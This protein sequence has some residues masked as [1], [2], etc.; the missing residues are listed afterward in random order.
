MNW[1]VAEALFQS[2][3]APQIASYSPLIERTYFLVSADAETAANEKA[4]TLARSKEHSYANAE[5]DTVQWSFLKIERVREVLDETL[6]DG[7]EVWSVI[8]RGQPDS[9]PVAD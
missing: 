2:A 4:V 5:G 3:I 6:G 1:Y 7:T 8:Y 9:D